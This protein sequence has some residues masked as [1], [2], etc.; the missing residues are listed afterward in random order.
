MEE[1][2]SNR[3]FMGIL[4]RNLADNIQTPSMY[5]LQDGKVITSVDFA[6]DYAKLNALFHDS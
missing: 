1:S 4:R 6:M 3:V 5:L 2:A